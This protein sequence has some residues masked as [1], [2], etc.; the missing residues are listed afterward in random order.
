MRFGNNAYIIDYVYDT[1]GRL[2]SVTDDGRVIGYD[3]DQA[4]NRDEI[5]WP[6]GYSAH[7][8]YDALNRL[9]TIRENS[10]SGPLLADYDY[11]NRSRRET[12]QFG[13]NLTTTYGYFP[14]SALNTL[15]HNLTGTGNDVLFTFGFNKAN[16]V[17]SINLTNSTYEYG[18]SASRLSDYVPD[19]LNQYDSVTVDGVAATLT[20]DDNGSLTNDGTWSYGYDI[21]NRL[22]TASGPGVSAI[23]DYDPLG[24]R[25]GKSGSGVP[26]EVYLVDGDTEIADY[27]GAGNLLRRYVHG[28][29]IDE[30]VVVYTGSG[31]SNKAYY[32]ADWRGSIVALSD[33]SGALS[34]RFTYSSFGEVDDP[35]GNPFRFTGRRIDAETGL[36]YYRARYY[37][38]TLGRFLQTDPIGYEDDINWYVYVKNE[39]VNSTDPTGEVAWFIPVIACSINTAC[40]T[41]ATS[42]IGAA[43]G[44]A[45]AGDGERVK[46]AQKG[47][48]T[49][50]VAGATLNA[51]ATAGTAA[52]LGGLD[53]AID[54]ATDGDPNTSALG[55]GLGQG[56]AEAM[57]A[58]AGM[59]TSRMALDEVQEIVLDAG[60][61]VAGAQLMESQ[62]AKDVG[63]TVVNHLS[64]TPLYP[65][66]GSTNLPQTPPA[67][68][69]WLRQP[70]SGR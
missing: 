50:A 13:N 43:V 64:E 19:G 33:G 48:L 9:D 61:A 26:T 21:E 41:L 18:S 22:I 34:D 29:G 37:S 24:R 39:P 6:D 52:V 3:Y 38:P 45:T 47:A 12:L 66:A 57:S 42:A 14:D 68:E 60:G 27:D 1:A 31:T 46:G 2:S 11:D 40:R 53:G 36:Y 10:T 28:P 15:E 56:A 51:K 55:S 8:Y 32:H 4:S 59:G 54:G 35:T 17:T 30:P 62:T 7:Y 44:A 65:N 67:D 20:H 5:V 58:V 16:Q 69:D 49:G 23:Y 63:N 70:D 25:A